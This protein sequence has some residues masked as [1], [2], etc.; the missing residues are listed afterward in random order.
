MAKHSFKGVQIYFEEHGS[1]PCVVLIHGFLEGTWMWKDIIP[2][3]SKRNRVV[4]IDLPGHGKS[5]NIGYVHQMDEMAEC[6][7]SIVHALGIRRVT[8]IGHS[9]GG[10]VALA[11]AELYP[12]QVR[13]LVLYQSTARDDSPIKKKHRTRA[14]RLIQTNHKSFI[15]NSIPMLFRPKNRAIFR[16]QINQLKAEALKTSRQGVIAALTGMRDRPNREIILKFAPYP[17]DIIASD[18]DPR[19]PLE[20]SIYLSELS[21]NVNLVLIK[22]AGHISYIEALDDTIQA[23]KQ[24]M[25]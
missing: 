25:K 4:A 17:V 3:I 21:E 24:V 15:R 20:E 22:D 10:Y 12:D 16:E 7:Q 6:V 18:Y 1:G 2:I 23:F 19:I 8:L 5:D 11:F 9:M 13:K 14:M